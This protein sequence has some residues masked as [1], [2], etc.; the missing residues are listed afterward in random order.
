VQDALYR[1]SYP[2]DF[3]EKREP[4][5]VVATTHSPFFLDLYKDHLEEIVIAKKIGQEACF[6]RLSEQ[7]HIDEIVQDAHLGDAWYTGILGGVPAHP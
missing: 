6:E 1:L 3:G 5:Q 2:E 4:V 7:P